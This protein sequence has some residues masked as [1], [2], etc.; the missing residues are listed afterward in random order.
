[1]SAKEVPRLCHGTLDSA[2]NKHTGGAKRADKKDM[3]CFI[4]EGRLQQGDEANAKKRSNKR[5]EL[6]IKIH[7]SLLVD[8]IPTNSQIP[9]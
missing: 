9:F 1:M 7:Q 8:N 4:Q 2:K 6:L 3:I 5:P